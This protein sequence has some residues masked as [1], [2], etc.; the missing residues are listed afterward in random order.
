M[1]HNDI[2]SAK[3][4]FGIANLSFWLILTFLGLMIPLSRF[5]RTPD[6]IHYYDIAKNVSSGQGLTTF[7]LAA[8]I[9]E[10][11]SPRI[12]WPPMYPLILAALL[13]LGIGAMTAMILVHI[14]SFLI[15]TYALWKIGLI[16]HSRLLGAIIAGLWLIVALQ[17]DLPIHPLSEPVF[18]AISCLLLLLITYTI[19]NRK[20]KFANFLLIGLLVGLAGLCRFAGLA[21]ILPVLILPLLLRSQG[22]IKTS[23]FLA[24]IGGV[25]LGLLIVIAPYLIWNLNA[26]GELF[27]LHRA[28]TEKGLLF[29]MIR[30]VITMGKD[31]LIAFAILAFGLLFTPNNSDFKKS[32]HRAEFINIIFMLALWI[33]AYSGVLLYATSHY[34]MDTISTRLIIPIYP[35]IIVLL[36]YLFVTFMGNEKLTAINNSANPALASILIF[37]VIMGSSAMQLKD[38]VKAMYSVQEKSSC[39]SLINWIADNTGPDDLIIGDRIWNVRYKTGRIVLESGYPSEPPLDESSIKAFLGKFGKNFDKIYLVQNE[40]E[41]QT[42][43]N[44]FTAFED[45]GIHPRNIGCFEIEGKDVQLFELDRDTMNK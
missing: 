21:L 5:S 4:K 42:E 7:H 27:P 11:P 9:E 26:T 33:I 36:G 6:S 24:G 17:S 35:I 2:K 45:D 44:I 8:D 29:N 41:K 40:S 38:R 23:D 20:Y 22:T 19:K 31:L 14:A 34:E 10:I 37:V 3:G 18:I 12:M 32:N 13:K 39:S 1:D 25:L 43:D 30:I 28:T 16:L 15:I